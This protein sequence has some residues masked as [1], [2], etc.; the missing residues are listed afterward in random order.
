MKKTILLILVCLTFLISGC[1]QGSPE[2]KTEEDI[3]AEVQAELEA[4]EKLKEELRAE[5]EA[6]MADE[7][8]L[9]ATSSAERPLL[10]L[11]RG[12]TPVTA[13][14]AGPDNEKIHMIQQS[15]MPLY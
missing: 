3:R 9:D 1:S 8:A 13:P 4:E 7:A 10:I 12:D 5:I 14:D 2:V 11:K 15:L 6:E